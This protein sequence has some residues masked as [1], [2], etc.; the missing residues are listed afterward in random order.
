[1][2]HTDIRTT[3]PV[4][5][6]ERVHV[7]DVLRGFAIFGMWIVNMTLDVGWSYRVDLMPMELHDDLTATVVQ[8]F[9]SGKFFTIFSFLFG[10]GAFIQIERIRARGGN[11]VALWLR[12]AAG[13]L[14]IAYVAFAATAR[15]SIL[16]DYAMIGVVLLLFVDRTPRT[17]LTAAVACIV[18]GIVADVGVPEYQDLRE[19]R[20]EARELGITVEAAAE[21]ADREA[22]ERGLAREPGI[23]SATFLEASKVSLRRLLERHTDW[24]EY[25]ELV[26]VLGLML[27]GLWVA[28]VG[29]VWDPNVRESVARASAPWLLAVG[30]ACTLL[31]WVITDFGIGDSFSYGPRVAG[32]ALMDP[33]GS[34]ATGLGYAATVVLLFRREGWRT[35]LHPFGAVGRMALTCYLFS[36]LS[37][38]FIASGWGLG[39]FGQVMPAEGLLVVLVLFPLMA[40]ACNWWLRYFRFGPA[41]W[42]WRCMTYGRLQPM[43]LRTTDAGQTL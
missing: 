2:D 27:V 28:S 18:L 1:M 24:Q 31:A 6:K 36:V 20:S 4:S 15:V 7:L 14:L 30:L 3:G 35:Y 29:G 38:S 11:H 25:G 17:M 5:S 34:S 41:E 10:V 13:L 32:Q 33:I 21:N 37:G 12:R 9:F 26:G 39:L 16:V 19:L 8:L 22:V 43:R 42:A 40:L 23:R